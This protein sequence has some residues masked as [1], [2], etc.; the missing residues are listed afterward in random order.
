MTWESSLNGAVKVLGP[1]QG[2]LSGAP[3]RVG[4]PVPKCHDLTL[5]Q[6]SGASADAAWQG[7]GC[8]LFP[9]RHQVRGLVCGVEM[10]LVLL[11]LHCEVPGDLP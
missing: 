3:H 2:Q 1:P 9:T 8:A 7:A 4:W 6:P 5:G 11:A 10:L